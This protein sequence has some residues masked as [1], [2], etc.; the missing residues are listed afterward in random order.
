MAAEV[1]LTKVKTDAVCIWRS[2][3]NGANSFMPSA[4]RSRGKRG[5]STW[6]TFCHGLTTQRRAILSSSS[7]LNTSTV[8]G[9]EMVPARGGEP[10][11]VA[12]ATG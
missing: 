7:V 2:R 9:I 10:W 4:A 5:F 3:A 8:D 1:G 6:S 11:L 12:T